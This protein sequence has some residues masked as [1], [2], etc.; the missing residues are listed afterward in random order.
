M[1]FF[2]LIQYLLKNASFL[3]LNLKDL[4]IPITSSH[5]DYIMLTFADMCDFNI[6]TLIHP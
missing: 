3:K 5:E 1:L 6:S 2:N 4:F